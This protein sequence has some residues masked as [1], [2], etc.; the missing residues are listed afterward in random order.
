MKAATTTLD[1][2]DDEH[3]VVED[4]VQDGPHGT[5]DRIQCRDDGDG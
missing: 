2:K 3:L 5:E 4:A 1:R